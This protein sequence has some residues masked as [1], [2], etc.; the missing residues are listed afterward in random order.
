MSAVAAFY[1]LK[2]A[3]KSTVLEVYFLVSLWGVF[4]QINRCFEADKH[5]DYQTFS[6]V[7]LRVE[8]FTFSG[9]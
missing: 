1:L 7:K 2:V 8:A 9:G 3:W 4:K 5:S 6:A